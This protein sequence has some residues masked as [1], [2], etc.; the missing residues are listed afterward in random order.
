MPRQHV[1]LKGKNA[2]KKQ[3][4]CQMVQ[5]MLNTDGLDPC[6]GEFFDLPLQR[7][8]TDAHLFKAVEVAG[9]LWQAHAAFMTQRLARVPDQPGIDQDVL[10]GAWEPAADIDNHYA[11]QDADLRRGNANA[12]FLSA[13]YAP[14]CFDQIVEPAVKNSDFLRF[15]AQAGI[16]KNTNFVHERPFALEFDHVGCARVNF[17]V[18]A[19]LEAVQ[20][21]LQGL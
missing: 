3:L 8:I 18:K 19:A 2:V 20:P 15:L 9:I 6:S 7:L 1:G 16:R 14:Q 12:H 5:L 13:H 10:T 11:L 4:P 21:G 17:D